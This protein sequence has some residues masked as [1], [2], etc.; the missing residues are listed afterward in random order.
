MGATGTHRWRAGGSLARRTIAVS[1]LLSAAIGAAFF[2]VAIAIGTL[3][4]SED[5]AD[6]A[7]EMLVAANHLERTIIDVE[8]T[9]RG[10][11]ITDDPR[12]LTPWYHAQAGYM[13]QADALDDLT[14]TSEPDQRLQAGQITAAGWSY[15]DDYAI[16]LIAMAQ[17]DQNSA[18]TVAVTE[19]GKRQV[20]ALRLRFEQFM[21]REQEIFAK[22]HERADAAANR[23]LVATSVGVGGTNLLLH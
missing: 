7:L 1:A 15:I 12:F 10:Y 21:A 6:H 14:R 8:T 9:Q 5:H 4:N 17:R 16:P 11:V 23:A 2:V 18:R 20:D 22:G 13:R 3:R 19:E